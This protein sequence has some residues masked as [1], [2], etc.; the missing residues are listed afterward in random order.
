MPPQTISA[1]NNNNFFHISKS[2]KKKSQC[3]VHGHLNNRLTNRNFAWE[4]KERAKVQVGGNHYSSQ[5]SKFHTTSSIWTKN[6]HPKASSCAD[7]KETSRNISYSPWNQKGC[8]DFSTSQF[9]AQ[10]DNSKTCGM[11]QSQSK[12]GG[13]PLKEVF[14]ATLAQEMSILGMTSQ[15]PIDLSKRGLDLS[16]SNKW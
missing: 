2:E 10:K 12:F 5:P 16:M 15:R 13:L 11:Y 8:I 4:A 1:Q 9:S 6:L 3:P 14:N 7:K